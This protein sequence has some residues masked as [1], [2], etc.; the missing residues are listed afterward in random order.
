[1][2]LNNLKKANGST[3][4]PYRKGRGRGTGNG[5]TCGKGQK[6]QKS[7][8]GHMKTGFEGGQ[9]PLYRRL[10]KFGFKNH[11]RVEY[12]TVDVSTLNRYKEGSKITP[13]LLV[14]DKIVKDEKDGLKILGNGEL[15]VKLNVEAHKFS[16]SAKEKIEK[17]G[18]TIKEIK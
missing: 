12:A 1:M 13:T 18:G 16:K 15:K 3:T 8:S 2:A 9:N 11:F 6:G 4:D 10:P 17:L 5:K 14:E 7:R